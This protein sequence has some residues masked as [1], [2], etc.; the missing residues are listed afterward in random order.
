MLIVV[1]G[2][3]AFAA[4]DCAGSG[5]HFFFFSYSIW[6]LV[7]GKYFRRISIFFS[8][9]ITS[10]KTRFWRRLCFYRCRL[11][12]L[13][14]MICAKKVSY[15]LDMK[16]HLSQTLSLALVSADVLTYSTN[17]FTYLFSQFIFTISLADIAIALNILWC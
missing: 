9:F 12:C 7:V 8:F 5:V 1:V 16:N 15:N 14:V 10:A 13:S 4:W 2:I 3:V 6:L 11:L 17:L